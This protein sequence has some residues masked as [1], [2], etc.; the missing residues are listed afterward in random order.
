K[1]LFL[2]TTENDL[3]YAVHYL[4]CMVQQILYLFSTN[5]LP[6]HGTQYVSRTTENPT[7][8]QVL[9]EETQ[10]ILSICLV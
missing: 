6:N 7:K 5:L 1:Y 4:C 8:W 3:S 9:P 2:S 10:I